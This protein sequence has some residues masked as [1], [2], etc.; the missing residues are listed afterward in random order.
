VAPGR[1][2]EHSGHGHGLP[3]PGQAGPD[4]GSRRDGRTVAREPIVA[5]LVL[6]P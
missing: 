4:R 6:Q 5:Q 2:Q 1:P 3:T